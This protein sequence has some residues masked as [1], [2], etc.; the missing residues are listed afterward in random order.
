MKTVFETLSSIN[1]NDKVEKKKNLT[2]LSWAWAWGEV[3]KH[4]EDATYEVVTDHEGKPYLY[5][6]ALGYM[7]RTTVTIKGETLGMWLPVMD[8]S[9]RAMKS[10]SYDWTSRYSSG[11]VE[12]ATM[13]DINKALMRCLTKN[14]AMFGLGH[15]IYAGEDL[16]Q[17]DEPTQGASLPRMTIAERDAIPQQKI[18]LVVDDENWIKVL[19]WVTANKDMQFSDIL[20][21]L[22]QKYV[23]AKEAQ[24][25]IRE[26][27]S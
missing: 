17:I 5:D 26:S 20:K 2:Y 13:F 25:K 3:K 9:N 8:T 23:V 21:T 6:D 11:T 15:Y 18:K 27:I 24:E 1:L 14:L 22:R 7:V 4:Y 19:K 12:A 16:P 10:H